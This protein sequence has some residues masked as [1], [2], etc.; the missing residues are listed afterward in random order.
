MTSRRWLKKFGPGR[1]LSEELF[2][3]GT[4]KFTHCGNILEGC[5]F[6]V[7]TSDIYKKKLDFQWLLLTLSTC[8]VRLGFRR[9]SLRAGQ[10][11][12]LHNLCAR[13]SSSDVKDQNLSSC[14][15]EKVIQGTRMRSYRWLVKPMSIRFHIFSL[16]FDKQLCKFLHRRFLWLPILHPK[17][18]M[19]LSLIFSFFTLEIFVK[20]EIIMKWVNRVFTGFAEC[21]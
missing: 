11:N 10:M 15:R 21:I 5:Y 2:K 13:R 19:F 9:L 8:T 20:S 4:I 18:R 7:H 12:G 1:W 14:W 6:R 3:G 16:H 17:M